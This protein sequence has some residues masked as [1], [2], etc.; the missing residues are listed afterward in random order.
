MVSSFKEKIS[1][2]CGIMFDL[3]KGL[4]MV[5]ICTMFFTFSVSATQENRVLKINGY[6]HLYANLYK[7][8]D[9]PDGSD[10]LIL[11]YRF[12]NESFTGSSWGPAVFFY[13]G[14]DKYI[15]MRIDSINGN[16][17]L[18]VRDG[19]ANV[20]KPPVEL[21]STPK[22][23]WCD[24]RVVL[25]MVNF[26]VNFY[27]RN[28]G[29]WEWTSV[30]QQSLPGNLRSKPTGIVI[31]V[32]YTSTGT[33]PYLRQSYTSSGALGKIYF[34]DVVL[35]VG[36]EVIFKEDFEKSL[37]EL[38]QEYDMA[39][40]PQNKADVLQVATMEEMFQVYNRIWIYPNPSVDE[41]VR[42]AYFLSEPGQ[43]VYIT[44]YDE[45]GRKVF[46]AKEQHLEAGYNEFFWDGK[47]TSGVPTAKGLYSC[48]LM[49]ED[50][51]GIPIL[52][53]AMIVRG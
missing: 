38:R 10:T 12:N 50:V 34:D 37:E 42:I 21:F 11:K 19:R 9:F 3:K 51:S 47:D 1:K 53:K 40:D 41:P 39:W 28:A 13:W 30:H 16:Y 6:G 29:E 36:K 17:R 49:L 20:T 33:V 35:K 22:N 8:I 44:I 23:T 14:P 46:Q 31:G 5:F 45:E 48:L 18:E 2:G 15:G 52:H 26:E 43:E 25:D 7:D 27:G 32:G 24:I 4:I